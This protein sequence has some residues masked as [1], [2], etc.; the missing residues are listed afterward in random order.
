MDAYMTNFDLELIK[1]LFRLIFNTSLLSFGVTMLLIF[2]SCAVYA[3]LDF[4]KST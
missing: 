4:V 2:G 1:E 3:V